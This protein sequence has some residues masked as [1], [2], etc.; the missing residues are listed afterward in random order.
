MQERAKRQPLGVCQDIW[1]A[2][3]Y[4]VYG[5]A[6]TGKAAHNLEQSGISSMTLHKFLKSFEEGRCQYNS[7]SVLVLD[8]AGMVDMERFEKLLDAVKQL[9][10]KLIVVGDGAQLQPVEAGPAFRLVSNRLGKAELNTVLR[11]KEDWQKEATVLFG[12]QETQAAIQKYAD[13]G[14]VHIV[15]EKLPSFHEALDNGDRE[16]IVKLYE[17]SSRTS[18]LMFREMMKECPICGL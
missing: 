7:N 2:E 11:Q 18:S 1:K 6:P 14:H 12:Q 16:A 13:K 5:L 4:A 8:E 17:I 10:V 3:D 9:G 15:E